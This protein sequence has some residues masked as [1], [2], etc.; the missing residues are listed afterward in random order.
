MSLFLRPC[1]LLAALAVLLVAASA[2]AVAKTEFVVAYASAVL[3]ASAAWSAGAT[4]ATKQAE[5]A[6]LYCKYTTHASSTTGYPDLKVQFSPDSATTWYD[7]AV[8]D[9]ESAGTTVAG[10]VDEWQGRCYVRVWYIDTPGVGAT[11]A[12]F[13]VLE[14]DLRAVAGSFAGTGRIRMLGREVG[15]GTNRGTLAC[16]WGLGMIER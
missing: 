11:A 4:T 9:D 5:V 6:R 1:R 10:G 3:P 7:Y 13:P 2:L 16:T 12:S 15:D 8:C 14:F